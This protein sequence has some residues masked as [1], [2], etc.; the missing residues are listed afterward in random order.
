MQTATATRRPWFRPVGAVAGL[1]FRAAPV[2]AGVCLAITIAAGIA[3]AG[4]AFAIRSLLDELTSGKRADGRLAVLYVVLAVGL[5]AVSLV[6]SYVASYL[7]SYVQQKVLCLAEDRLYTRVAT[8][9]G[10]SNIENPKFHDTMRLAER[11]VETAPADLSVFLVSAVRQ[12]A[13]AAVYVG[14]LLAVWPPM[15]G[16]LVLAAVPALITQLLLARQATRAEIDMVSCQR[17]RH[18]FRGARP[19]SVGR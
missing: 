5:G 18:Y 2:G 9:T 1:T 11:A 15:M 4:A 19:G 3:P 10:L 8:F 14:L 17:R 12:G 7:S 13:N 6:A 16:L